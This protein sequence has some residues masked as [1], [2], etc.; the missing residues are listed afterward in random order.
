GRLIREHGIRGRILI[1]SNPTVAAR[2]LEPLLNS[3]AA[4]GYQAD[5]LQIPDG[6]SYK[7]LE[8]AN[9]IYD[10][11]A[12][13]EYDRKSALIALGG[14]VIGDLTGFVAA[15]YMRGIQFIQV[16]TTL[17]AQVDSSVGGK[18]AVNHPQGKNLIGTFYQPALVLTDVGTLATLP[19]RELSSG[20]AEVIKH[21]IIADPHYYQLVR[22]EI[23]LLREAN[24]D[25]LAWVVAGSCKIK[26]EVVEQDERETGLRAILNFGHT[27]GHACESL[28]GYQYFRHGEGVALGML[29]AVKI[30]TRL[31]W[32]TDPGLEASLLHL[33]RELDLPVTL[34]GL[35]VADLFSQL[36]LDKKVEYGKIRWVMPKRLGEVFVSSEIPQPVVEA[37]LLEMGGVKR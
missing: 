37:V 3:L 16:P 24:A 4:A 1:V 36:Y 28:T 35:E 25:L 7:S 10:R 21:G 30:A 15:T 19:R 11:L 2:Y 29:A 18:V 17:L 22:G 6:E 31:N 26:A 27:I 34:P 12:E 32:L 20:M 33:L 14:G 9:R 23:K 8:Q 13:L 5:S